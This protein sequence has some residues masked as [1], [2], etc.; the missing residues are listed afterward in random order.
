M[1]VGGWREGVT[2][3]R[4]AM[5][6][7]WPGRLPL[8]WHDDA[9]PAALLR[10]DADALLGQRRQQLV[11]R[12]GPP[13][14]LEGQADQGERVPIGPLPHLVAASDRVVGGQDV[15]DNHGGIRREHV[16]ERVTQA[17]QT[18]PDLALQGTPT[19]SVDDQHFDGDAPSAG[20]P[21]PD[22]ARLPNDSRPRRAKPQNTHLEPVTETV[23]HGIPPVGEMANAEREARRTGEMRLP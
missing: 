1:A 20:E 18:S 9:Q 4:G 2:W 22:A 17:R 21:T 13:V 5:V 11:Q 3:G 15:L 23:R 16:T 6:L 12:Q 7:G 8:D 14:D 10:G 19:R